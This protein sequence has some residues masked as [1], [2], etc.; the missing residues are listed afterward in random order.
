[1]F[2]RLLCG[3]FLAILALIPLAQA[4]AAPR[5]KVTLAGGHVPAVVVGGCPLLAQTG[6]L[7]MDTSIRHE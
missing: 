6:S 2:T 4:R 3:I 7:P 1:M 5:S